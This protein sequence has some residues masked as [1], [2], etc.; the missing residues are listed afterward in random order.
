MQRIAESS[1]E[2]AET[3]GMVAAQAQNGHEII[4]GAVGRM[5]EMELS[6]TRISEL[7]HSFG[8][9]SGQ[10]GN[11]VGF[12]TEI[13]NQTSML[14][15]NAAIEA[16]RA[17]EYGRGFSVVAGEVKKLSEQTAAAAGHISS[18]ISEIQLEN[19]KAADSMTANAVIVQEG[20]RMV[21]DAGQLFAGILNGVGG[22]R[23][24]IHEVSS[25]SQQLLAGTEE[26]TSTV[27]HMAEIAGQA[28]SYSQSVAA[29]SEEQLAS[30]GEVAGAS[31]QLAKTADDMRTAITRFKVS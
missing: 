30:M 16:A 8:S 4:S 5:K 13:S 14:A 27:E 29:S 11:I 20:S 22:I 1:M 28:V 23:T 18:L 17:G 25:S 24:Q 12:I 31:T 3:A 2:A 19:L 15:L 6:A 21:G 9:R 10:I 7:I 26:L